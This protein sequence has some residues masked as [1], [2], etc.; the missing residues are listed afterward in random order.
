[1]T[2]RAAL[3]EATLVDIV[4]RVTVVAGRCSHNFLAGGTRMTGQA[5]KTF[6]LAI[7][8]EMR[9]R[10]V[11]ELPGLPAIRVVTL[12]AV[13]AEMALVGIVLA[14]TVRADQRRIFVGGTGVTFLA[15]GHGMR[16]EQRKAGQVMFEGYLL[17][18]TGFVVTTLAVTPF[19]TTMR[20]VGFMAGNAV[21]AEFLGVDVAGMASLTGDFGV[22]TVQ[23]VFGVTVVIESRLRPFHSAVAALAITAIA[24]LMSIVAT[25]TTDTLSGQ[26]LLFRIALVTHRAC[27]GFVRTDK[28]EM[29]VAVMVEAGRLPS[30]GAV[31]ASA[32]GT[33]AALMH[34]VPL[35]AGD[36]VGGGVFVTLVRMTTVAGNL[37]ML[38]VQFVM[39][40]VMIEAG[41]FPTPLVVAI[42][43][44]RT[45]FTPVSIIFLMT[46]E[47]LR[48]RFA[49]C[50]PR[51]V[52]G[53]ALDLEMCP[54]QR[55]IRQLVRKGFPVESYDIHGTALVIGMTG[56]ALESRNTRYAT[57]ETG[58]GAQIGAHLFVTGQA[59]LVL[60]L[61]AEQF[62]AFSALRFDL[63]M[64][65][66]HGPR[67]HQSLH[68][69]GPSGHDLE[70]QQ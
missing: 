8:L 13:L 22:P 48:G 5:I 45:E 7:E 27:G 51:R 42:R 23:R 69:A 29:G 68:L 35:M 26:L 39:G 31:A 21:R 11:I 47:T 40:L 46:V 49:V 57:V 10:V 64:R 34:I 9:A 41:V 15:G 60:A 3:A 16:T 62:M 12:R 38:A 65:L 30:F 63:G 24:T 32:F 33:E 59:Q 20:V 54:M 25:M 58:R 28:F 19:L 36:T 55:I 44:G 61:V 2:L 37:D 43:A 18:P 14:M 56:L 52:T 17:A 66:G 1:M 6:M 53:R 70:H 67:H 50:R 4:T